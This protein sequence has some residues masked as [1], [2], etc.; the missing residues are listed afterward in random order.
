MKSSLRTLLGRC[1]RSGPPKRSSNSECRIAT[2]SRIGS[3]GR[4]GADSPSGELSTPQRQV[5]VSSTSAISPLMATSESA[6]TEGS[7]VLIVMTWSSRISSDC[8]ISTELSAALSDS[9]S[10]MQQ[11]FSAAAGSPPSQQEHFCSG[12]ATWQHPQPSQT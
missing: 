5:E 3:V 7:A 2:E 6:A 10:P 4:A 1:G 8:V 11:V 12:E 9:A